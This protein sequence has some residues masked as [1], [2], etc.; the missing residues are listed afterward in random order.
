MNSK[1]SS[2]A[3]EAHFANTFALSTEFW[4]SVHTLPMSSPQPLS[5]EPEP[6]EH[7][8][9]QDSAN[10]AGGEIDLRDLFLR[11]W[12]G[13]NQVVGFALLGLVLAALISLGLSWVKPVATT[14]RVV[15]SFEGIERGEYPDKSKFQPDD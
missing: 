9:T 1:K 11:V 14:T 5:P 7:R 10:E 12:R 2:P 4:Q 6:Q 15:F 3:A 13:A 8:P